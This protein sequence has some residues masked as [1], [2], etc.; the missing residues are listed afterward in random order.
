MRC[1][2]Y[3]PPPG[4]APGY[5]NAHHCRPRYTV[6]VITGRAHIA[7][8]EKGREKSGK[9]AV[10]AAA[11]GPAAARNAS[12]FARMACIQATGSD[13]SPAMPKTMTIYS[14]TRQRR[15]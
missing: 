3:P 1:A 10:G 6:N 11:E 12:S 9:K 8:K 14:T 13:A 2:M 5:Q 15:V 4:S 7:W